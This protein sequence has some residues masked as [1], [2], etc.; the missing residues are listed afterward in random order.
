M[1]VYVCLFVY[2]RSMLIMKTTY[3]SAECV[4]CV[5]VCL[6]V[7]IRSMLIMK[8]TYKSAEC[9]YVCLRVPLCLYSLY[10]NN[11]NNV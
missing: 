1:C 6:F 3:K 9:V 5:Y 8:T 4:L 2:I 11:E 7:Y 10:A